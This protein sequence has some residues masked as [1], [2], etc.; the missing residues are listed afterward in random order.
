M[1][2]IDHL[3]EAQGEAEA[4]GSPIEEEL[5]F[6]RAFFMGLIAGVVLNKRKEDT[7]RALC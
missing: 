1:L 2:A 5:L 4:S 6:S 3:L 7:P